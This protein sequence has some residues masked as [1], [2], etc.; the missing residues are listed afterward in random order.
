MRVCVLACV[1][2]CVC[3]RAYVRA[4]VRA[5]LY[6]E[7]EPEGCEV[8]EGSGDAGDAEEEVRESERHQTRVG[9]L[10]HTTH[11]P[12]DSSLSE[13]GQVEDVTEDTEHEDDN[14]HL[15][16]GKMLSSSAY[17]RMHSLDNIQ[18]KIRHLRNVFNMLTVACSYY[19]FNIIII[20]SY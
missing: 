20:I 11:R 8:D 12:K 13:H 4:C 7:H 17:C 6:M 14:V 1:R 2:V 10:L 19:E 3:V 15:E 9:R 18:G 5:Y 16:K